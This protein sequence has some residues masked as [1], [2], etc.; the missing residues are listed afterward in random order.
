MFDKDEFRKYATKHQGISST[1]Y[2]KY[3]HDNE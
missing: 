2:D 1:S 3:G